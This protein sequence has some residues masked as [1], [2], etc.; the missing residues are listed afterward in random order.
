MLLGRGRTISNHKQSF[1]GFIAHEMLV[2]S[3][4]SNQR[5]NEYARLL[6]FEKMLFFLVSWG[7]QV[8]TVN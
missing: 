6:V 1:T 4:Q 8:L 7:Q 2:Y 5:L 3:C